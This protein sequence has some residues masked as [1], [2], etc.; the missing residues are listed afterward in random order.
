MDVRHR[1]KKKKNAGNLECLYSFSD[2]TDPF[3]LNEA[4]VNTVC[5]F[6]KKCL[7]NMFSC[8]GS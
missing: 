8:D 6:Q 2:H 1:F 4:N 7:L 5:R 3:Y